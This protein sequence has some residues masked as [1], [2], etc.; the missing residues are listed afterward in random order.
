MKPPVVLATQAANSDSPRSMRVELTPSIA[1]WSSFAVG[2]GLLVVVAVLD[3]TRPFDRS[4]SILYILVALYSVW[5]MHGRAELILHAATILA[6]FLVP[7]ANQPDMLWRGTGLF[8]RFTGVLSGI[9]LI[10][11]VWD[12]RRIVVA[13]QQA[14]R[15]LEHRVA[16]RTAQLQATN[17]SLRC[18]NLAREKS[19]ASLR[20][21]QQCFAL[22]MQHLPGLAWIKDAQGRYVYANEEAANVFHKSQVELYG[23]TDD[24]LFPHETA[25]QFKSVDQQAFFSRSAVKTVETL[26][27]D[28]GVVHH[29]IVC[30]FPLPSAEGRESLI[31]GM[32][33]DITERHQAQETIRKISGFREAIIRTAAEGI[34]VCEF[35]P[36]FPYIGFSV[37]NEQMT[38]ITGFTMVEINRL[39]WYQTLFPE[40]KRRTTAQERMERV[41]HGDDMRSEE[42]EITC[43]DGQHR[44]VAI[45]TSG[46]EIEE[47][48]RGVVA[49]IQD[50]TE[51]KRAEIALQ[52]SEAS[53]R[54]LFEGANDAIFL[55]DAE[56]GLLI[57]CN[58]AAETL[59][60]RGRDEIVGQPQSFLHPPEDAERYRQLFQEHASLR[61]QTHVE[62]E[63][64]RKD[65]QRVVVS[66]SPSVT[67]IGSRTVIQGIFRDITERKLAEERLFATEKRL[68]TI[69]KS[70]PV[71]MCITTIDDGTMLELNDVC[72]AIWRCKPEDL[73]GRNALE[74][75]YWLVPD[76]R[77]KLVQDVLENRSI[78]GDEFKFRHRDGTIGFALRS[79]ERIKF[80]DQDCILSMFID[81]TERKRVEEA[82]RMMR[83]CVDHAGDSVFWVS[84]TGQILYANDAACRDRGYPRE[85]LLNMT[86]FDL[87]VEPDYRP[88]LWEKHFD[89]LKRRG[90]IT[91][92]TRHRSK[93]GRIL[94]VEVNANYVQFGDQEFNFA[95]ARDIT[96]RKRIDEE[97]RESRQRLESLSRQLITTQEIERRHLARELHDE[98]GQILT[99][100]KIR[101]RRSQQLADASLQSN[102]KEVVEIVDQAIGQVRNLALKLR[103]AQLD[104]LGLVAAL[105]WLVKS[106][107]NLGGIEE[108]FEVGLGNHDIPSEI[109][110]VC[111]RITQEALTNAIR[112]ARPTKVHVK[113]WATDNKLF[114]SIHDDGVGF[115]V[116]E[117]YRR[118]LEGGSF[119]LVS[120]QE[121]AKLAGGR[122]QIESAPGEETTI[123]AW[124]PL[125]GTR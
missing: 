2:I 22:F 79:I 117:T 35:L 107:A 30:R 12:R 70:C 102:L 62:A 71:G 112:H 122:V 44:I 4:W 25:V 16:A 63:V 9:V 11:I 87:D 55:A 93:D 73:L 89:E 95:F 91:L 20:G 113:L 49:V 57:N 120:M 1:T 83:F 90:A 104:E 119:G 40:P 99:A 96:Q 110:T 92:E 32:A 66:I 39:G 36:D 28:D 37:W 94:P 19:E 50:V 56:T 116:S 33:I 27:Y 7:L 124:F 23:N 46:V 65:G 103:P 77:Q 17:E 54:L 18:E 101:L 26:K 15:E 29:S 115:D 52:T 64:L 47:G 24:D 31:G 13:L 80:D 97:L 76:D 114:L 5:I 123:Q 67:T 21:S 53:F 38:E 84:R 58:R 41:W 14:N 108:E 85:E 42:W 100:I 51:R 118:A 111:F 61:K 86:V 43:Q 106:Q 69:F 45:S 125:E 68:E 8:Y 109:E 6:A 10:A 3:G 78:K 72:C 88:H 75:G 60:G 105:H 48:L 81:I 121:R 59:L 98:I 34:C 74:L 82:L